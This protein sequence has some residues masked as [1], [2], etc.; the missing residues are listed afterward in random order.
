MEKKI[1]VT[2]AHT[3]YT[4]FFIGGEKVLAYQELG[5]AYHLIPTEEPAQSYTA[6]SL[7]SK[8]ICSTLKRKG[9]DL[10]EFLSRPGNPFQLPSR[11]TT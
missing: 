7:A 5:G 8:A 3:G 1:E 4:L 10:Q 9:G 6:P 11:T 2:I